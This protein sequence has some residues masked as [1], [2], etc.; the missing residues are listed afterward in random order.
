VLLRLE[1]YRTGY[2]MADNSVGVDRGFIS[3]PRSWQGTRFR[4]FR[5]GLAETNDKVA[6]GWDRDTDRMIL[7][8]NS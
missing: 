4:G 7:T 8:D 3:H 1:K 5:Q 2:P 6:G